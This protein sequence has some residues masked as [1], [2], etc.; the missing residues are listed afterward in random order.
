MDLIL[1]AVVIF[2]EGVLSLDV[3]YGALDRILGQT[4]FDG[5]SRFFL[6]QRISGV[7]PTD[8]GAKQSNYQH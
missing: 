6:R 5:G 3:H 2:Y 8:S 7:C 4:L 1:F